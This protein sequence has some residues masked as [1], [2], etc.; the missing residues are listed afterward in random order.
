MELS[1]RFYCGSTR[2]T[3]A[4]ED[5]GWQ[6]SCTCESCRRASGAPAVGWINVVGPISWTGDLPREISINPG[7][8]RKFCATCGAHLTYHP[9]AARPGHTDVLAA[10]LERPELYRP[11]RWDHWDEALAGR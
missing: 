5:I 2:L 10:Q 7:V 11:T 1:A 6:A 9:D 4:E 8:T 3:F